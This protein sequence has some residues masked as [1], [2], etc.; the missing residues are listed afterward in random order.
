MDSIGLIIFLD[1]FDLEWEEIE[2]DVESIEFFYGEVDNISIISISD[3]DDYSSLLSIGSD[4][5]Y[6]S[7]SVK[8]LF[9]L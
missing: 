9:I 1:C 6:F 5:G 4:E 3:I 2:V 8:F 7:V